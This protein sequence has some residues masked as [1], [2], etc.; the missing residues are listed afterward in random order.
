MT[1]MLWAVMVTH[2][3]GPQL[4][5]Y[6]AALARQTRTLDHLLVV[7]NDP[8]GSARWIVD[9]HGLA[10]TEVRY[11]PSGENIGP[12]GGIAAGLRTVLG[13]ADDDDWVF[14]LDD[15]DPPQTPEMIAEIEA[16]AEGLVADGS[17]VGGV[18]LCGG[19]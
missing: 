1:L 15:D 11:Q 12:A 7:D 16:L 18:G 9:A 2:Q 19:R 10:H 4:R 13:E 8:A 5:E 6:F 17:P 3:R 14:T